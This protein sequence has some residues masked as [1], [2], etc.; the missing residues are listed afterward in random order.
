[1]S[2]PFLTEQELASGCV[3]KARDAQGELYARYAARLY[4]LCMRYI[5]NR[6]EARDLMHDSMIKAMD[7]FKSFRYL[8]EGSVWAWISS[9]TINLVV[10]RLKESNRFRQVPLELVGEDEIEDAL[11]PDAESVREIP[12]VILDEIIAE[13]PPVR[14]EV[15]NMYLI[16][17]FSHKEIAR[18][19]GI[20]EKGS[21][22]ILAKARQN[23]RKALISYLDNTG[24]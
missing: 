4:A 13:L 22:S 7:S 8:G 18:A 16:D 1:M 9:I 2:K 11:E 21:S 19:L 5:G 23:V 6:D 17:G 3:R 10:D 24:Q 20:T 14:R 15:F 12:D